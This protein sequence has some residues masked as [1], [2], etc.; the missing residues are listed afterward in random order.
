MDGQPRRK[1]VVDQVFGAN[2]APM[3]EVL[4]ADFTELMKAVTYAEAMCGEA[5]TKPKN[6]TEQAALG[7]KIVDMRRLLA[8]VDAVR[9]EEKAPILEAGRL[10]DGWFGALK[11]RIETA[12]KP[13][14]SGADAYV[15]EKAAAERARA[16]REAQ[17]AREKA[18]AKR[19]KAEAA[20]SA[21]AAGNAEARAEKLD[22]KA[23]AAEAAAGASAA[24]LTRAKV[25]GVS[26]GGKETW[27][28]EIVDYTTAIGPLGA[29]GPYFKEAELKSALNSM[30]RIQRGSAKWPGVNF[31]PD[32]KASFRK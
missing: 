2:K 29:L 26:M 13:L 18:E 8:R 30:A 12:V 27:V 20:K 14:T 5:N 31:R 17:E 4:E 32:V 24:D 22:A 16:A 19:R 15:H 11:A 21:E 6:D 1:P 7:D 23:D 10:L 28:A 3:T 9:T 25:G